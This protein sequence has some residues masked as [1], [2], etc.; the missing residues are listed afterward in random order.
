MLDVLIH[1]WHP[2]ELSWTLTEYTKINSKYIKDLNLR[3]ETKTLRGK[4]SWQWTCQRFLCCY[5]NST[6]NKSETEPH[7]VKMEPLCFEGH[8]SRVKSP[9]TEWAKILVNHKCCKRLIFRIYKE[10]LQLNSKGDPPKLVIEPGSPALQAD[11]L[12]SEPP[13]K[14]YFIH[15]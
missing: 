7:R 13:R 10:L 5:T 1:G 2:K 11:S 4:S 8:F 14:P 3:A 6:G 15:L 12:L 9:S